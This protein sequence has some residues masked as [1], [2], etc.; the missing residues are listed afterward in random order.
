[1]PVR[2]AEQASWGEKKAENRLREMAVGRDLCVNGVEVR[3]TWGGKWLTR[4][5]RIAGRKA[6][7]KLDRQW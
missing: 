4:S 6:L 1:M 2:R 5:R 3:P 7:G